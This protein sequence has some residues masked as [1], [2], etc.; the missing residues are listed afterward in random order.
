MRTVFTI[1]AIL[2]G[3]AF[4]LA[5]FLGNR[6]QEQAVDPTTPPRPLEQI[7]QTH[8]VTTP[9]TTDARPARNPPA[10]ASEMDSDA[11][12][13]Q[14]QPAETT[15]P[16]PAIS[17]STSVTGS[18]LHGLRPRPA[19]RSGP[20]T[21][22]S[23]DPQS[24]YKLQAELTGWG[25]AVRAIRLNRYHSTALGQDP[26]TIQ[27]P[28]KASRIEADGKTV[29]YS[30]YPF[31]ARAIHVNDQSIDLQKPSGDQP[32][33]ALV[34]P[35]Q[36]QLTLE[37]GQGQS[38]LRVTRRYWLDDQKAVYDLRC[39]QKVENLTGQP[40]EVVWEQYAQG[41][42]PP[43]STA[44]MGDRRNLAV[45]YR[46]FDYNPSGQ[47]VYTDGTF[48]PRQE[49]IA[50]SSLT[51]SYAGPWVFSVANNASPLWPNEG[52]PPPDDRSLVWAGALNRY[53][54]AVVHPVFDGN[55]LEAAS[56]PSSRPS[57]DSKFA[58]LGLYV[59][60]PV[61]Q[62][63]D[64]GRVMA[65]TLTSKPI[66]LAPGSSE[67]LDLSLYAGPRSTEVFEDPVYTGL[68]FAK[69]V[70]YNLGG[71]CAFCTFQWLAKGLLGFLKILHA[72]MFD[73][74]VA[75]IILVAVVRLILHPITKKAQINMMKMG[76]QMQAIQP[77]LE[78]LKKKYGE[79]PKRFQQEQMKLWREKGINPAGML[80]CLPM[81][82]QTPIWIALY[83]MLYY[84]IELRHQ[85]AFYGLFQAVSGGSWGFL[86]DLSSADRFISFFDEPQVIR[87]IMI[88]FDYSSLNILPL[89]MAVVFFFQQK[90][91]TPPPANEQAAQQ[92]K[93]M[94]FMVLLF[95]IMLYSAPSGLTLYI[96]ASTAA[97][98]LDSYI[99]RR[100][101]NEA[102]EAGTLFEKKE[103][104]PGG[105]MDRMQKALAAKQAEMMQV[106]EARQSG[107]AP[108]D[109]QASQA[110][111]TG[112]DDTIVAVSSPPGRSAR[113][114]VRLSGPRVMR[115]MGRLLEP[116]QSSVEHLQAWP[117]PRR[118]TASRIQ[119]PTANTI[120][121]EDPPV[122]TLPV[123]LSFFMAPR[124]YTGQ[125]MAELQCPG[126]PA[127]LDRVI[128]RT[129]GLG[130]RLA[131]PGEFTYRAFLAGK[132]DLTEAEGVA[133]TISAVSD[134]QLQAA[135]LLRGGELGRFAVEL[136]DQLSRHL[137]LVEAGIDFTDQ[138][139]VVPIAPGS[140][141]ERLEVIVSKLDDLLTRSR[142]W[143][144]LEALPRVVLVGAPSTGKSTLFNALLG[145]PR[146]V[147]ARTPGTTRD[148]LTEPLTL[149]T[150]SG[151][152]VEVMLVDIAGLDEPTTALDRDVQA[153][154]RQAVEQ[155]D[156]ILLIDDDQ[157]AAT[158]R[159]RSSE[160]PLPPR[161]P[162]LRVR[163]KTDLTDPRPT[164]RLHDPDWDSVVSVH[165]DEGLDDLRR[166]IL[167]RIGDRAVS[168]RGQML[169]LQ[170]RHEQA[171]HQAREA[172]EQAR[173][174]LA[175]QRHGRAI[176]RVE[177]VAGVMRQAL[178]QLA[179]LGGRV[180]PDEVIGKIFATFCIGK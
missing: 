17:S 87:L 113:G 97:G 13:A 69:L 176:D 21:I 116:P 153:A 163:T 137:A 62:G 104:K 131:E 43:D 142:S 88:S 158:V 141:D 110:E 19:T 127:L 60:G 25:A 78:K 85:P 105:F 128:R 41:D 84:A 45:G 54:A 39:D 112:V 92:Q 114:L 130:A 74:G 146:A 44:Y 10:T 40:L 33:W 180:T 135:S 42:V 73:W 11:S 18:L 122:V 86:A 138:E 170:P 147:T 106:Q 134:G 30:I 95:P 172:L 161:V 121:E 15:Q 63:A 117:T 144:S 82:L 173:D 47:F 59:F 32:V 162:V 139:D 152:A 3:L 5:V 169:A 132:M 101:I 93:I 90:F 65:F 55:D 111:M 24:P 72:I 154:A 29:T 6:P 1:V 89:L 79:D 46:N 98:V 100:H 35:G 37:N 76:K 133:A 49:V 8:D 38:I 165:R 168:V 2:I 150:A 179:A 66:E 155:A 52:L 51:G 166:A 99:V 118:L 148:V 14:T 16:K 151:T 50:E 96:L 67:S 83:A 164:G 4:S 71:P 7:E 56:S 80:G 77:E 108:Q 28:V 119:L 143:G 48:L 125:D 174:L 103:P 177:L 36:Y 159:E 34:A 178:D 109:R 53:F 58:R 94:K 27:Q 9:I 175:A 75:I 124:S 140:L 123:L 22:G 26:Y 68:G 23:V 57:L 145:R 20:S 129:I 136:V 120:N 61:G 31:A 171:L 160:Y 81:F 107:N 12:P 156:L 70:V 149:E 91:T 102:E 115:I 64:D 167:D 126:H 157:R